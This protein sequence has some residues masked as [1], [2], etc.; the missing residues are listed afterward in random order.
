MQKK[1]EVIKRALKLHTPNKSDPIDVLSKVGGYEIGA[2]AGC[3]LA[4]AN[5]KIPVVI[6]GF[7]ST[8]GA[9]IAAGLSPQVIEYLFS[10]H[11]SAENGHKIA[12]NCLKLSPLLDLNLRL[13]EGT[14]ACLAMNI[15]EASVKILTEMATFE[16]ARVSKEIGSN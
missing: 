16:E 14:G 1:I 2:I 10:S 8:T 5:Y 4:A 3:I 15:L 6:D 12:L 7:I 9:L 13:G 11:L